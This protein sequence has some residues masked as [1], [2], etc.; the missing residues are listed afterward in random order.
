MRSI[1][2]GIDNGDP[3]IIWLIHFGRYNKNFTFRI[4]CWRKGFFV[5]ETNTYLKCRAQQTIIVSQTIPIWESEWKPFIR[6]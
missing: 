1:D 2:F 3:N 6:Q 5:P 4:L